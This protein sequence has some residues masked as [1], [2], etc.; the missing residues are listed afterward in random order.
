MTGRGHH[1]RQ[2]F[3]GAFVLCAPSPH[4]PAL[5]SPLLQQAWG[6]APRLC[7][8]RPRGSAG[9]RPEGSEVAP[10]AAGPR[11][12]GWKGQPGSSLPGNPKRRKSSTALY[13]GGQKSWEVA[14]R[15]NCPQNGGTR[16]VRP[17]S[18]ARGPGSPSPSS[19]SVDGRC[20]EKESSGTYLP[21]LRQELLLKVHRPLHGRGAPHVLKV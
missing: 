1:N 15:R 11:F 17:E 7:C 3:P 13:Q 9:L 4:F 8:S 21:T 2:L 16:A 19:G 14:L 12:L 6:A 20:P 5:P 10:A 18:Q